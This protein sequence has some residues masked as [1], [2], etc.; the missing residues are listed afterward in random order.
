MCILT[1][2]YPKGGKSESNNMLRYQTN[3]QHI[4]AW[5]RVW[6][7]KM[8][9]KRNKKTISRILLTEKK[10]Y[11]ISRAAS[12]RCP[13]F[14]LSSDQSQHLISHLIPARH[15]HQSW[16]QNHGSKLILDNRYDGCY[17]RENTLHYVMQ[18]QC[19]VFKKKKQLKIM[20]AILKYELPFAWTFLNITK[21]LRKLATISIKRKLPTNSSLRFLKI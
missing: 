12:C 15:A 18:W 4:P 7:H 3:N 16:T 21:Y 14:G 6:Q 19:L 10:V 20:M 8:E 13:G 9:I 2:T 1:Q 17:N 11:L 5:G